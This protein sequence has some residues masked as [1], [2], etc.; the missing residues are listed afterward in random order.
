MQHHLQNYLQILARRLNWILPLMISNN[1]STLVKGRLLMEN[2]LLATEMVHRFDKNNISSR[3]V[4]KVDLREAFDTVDWT[5]I[6]QIM[7]AANFPSQYIN[8]IRQCITNTS[9]SINVNGNLCD[10]F[11]GK[12]PFSPLSLCYV[13]GSFSKFTEEECGQ[14]EIGLH[15]LGIQPRISHL[16][17]ADDI[18]IFF[19][20]M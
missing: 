11:Q 15:P 4:L 16:C 14:G 9:F 3:G 10:Y 1:Q 19:D 5:F 12:R 13:D 17:F 2:V 6:L 18:L 8:W 7:H 20:G